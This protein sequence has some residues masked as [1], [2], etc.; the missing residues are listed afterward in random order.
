[1]EITENNIIVKSKIHFP[2]SFMN[3]P[4]AVTLLALAHEFGHILGIATGVQDEDL[5]PKMVLL[6]ERGT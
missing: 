3:F 4:E 6:W 1:M 5:I 2:L